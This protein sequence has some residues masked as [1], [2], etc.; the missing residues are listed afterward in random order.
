[1]KISKRMEEISHRLSKEC[2]ILDKSTVVT[3]SQFKLLVEAVQMLTIAL[4]N[5]RSGI[6][7]STNFIQYTPKFL[8][9]R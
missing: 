6:S 9:R 5:T 4:K 2:D 1:M 3:P 8:E 7:K